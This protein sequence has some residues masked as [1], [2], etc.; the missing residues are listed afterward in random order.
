MRDLFGAVLT[1]DDT[2]SF[3]AAARYI[4]VRPSTLYQW[5]V[6]GVGLAPVADGDK[7][8]FDSAEVFAWTERQVCVQDA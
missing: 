7:L 3:T 6:D 2:M 8:R 4:R 5:V 1:M